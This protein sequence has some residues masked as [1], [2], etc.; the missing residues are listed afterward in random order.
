MK[1]ISDVN[2]CTTNAHN[3]IVNDI[4]AECVNTIGS[5]FCRCRFGYSGDA[6]NECLGKYAKATTSNPSF[7]D[8]TSLPMLLRVDFTP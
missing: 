6:V 1:S 4:I 5:F 3:C 8:L 7:I 2:E